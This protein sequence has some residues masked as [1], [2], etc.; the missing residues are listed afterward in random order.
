MQEETHSP[1]NDD[2]LRM[3]IYEQDCQSLRH[4]DTLTWSRFQTAATIE[5]GMLFG[6]YNQT[7]LSITPVERIA[8]AFVASL[9]VLIVSS[10]AI[11]DNRDARGHLKRVTEF[12]TPIAPWT[13]VSAFLP[14][15]GKWLLWIAV[16][17]INVVNLLVVVKFVKAAFPH[18]LALW[19]AFT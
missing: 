12:E 10:L 18:W 16:L 1:E 11:K 19:C 15:S 13:P 5:A 7:W 17:V 14:L 3:A 2:K 4:Q 6:L 9:L 8:L